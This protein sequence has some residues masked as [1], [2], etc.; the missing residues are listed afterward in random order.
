M[1]ESADSGSSSA[2]HQERTC[3]SALLESGSSSANRRE[4]TC[5]SD[6]RD[7]DASPAEPRVFE[8]ETLGLAGV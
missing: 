7:L 1:T 8:F 4:R 3:E 5:E 2:D 6:G